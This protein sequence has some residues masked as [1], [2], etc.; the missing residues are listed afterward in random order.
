VASARKKSFEVHA[1]YT[2]LFTELVAKNKQ[3][4]NKK[5]KEQKLN[6]KTLTKYYK[7]IQNLPK[8]FTVDLY[9]DINLSCLF[10]NTTRQVNSKVIPT[11]F[12]NSNSSTE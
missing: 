9:R 1:P 7:L 12:Y 5:T 11:V 6:Y 4:N 8:L 10:K 3:Q 2:S